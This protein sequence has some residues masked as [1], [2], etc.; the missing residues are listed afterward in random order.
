MRNDKPLLQQGNQEPLS[1]PGPSHDEETDPEEGPGRPLAD[2]ASFSRSLTE[3]SLE[4]QA[5]HP[6][7]S[8]SRPATYQR[9][10]LYKA[11]SLPE[12]WSS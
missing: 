2:A 10:D 6:P 4:C 8:V 12:S 3:G 1:H 5:A 11:V 7:G 9:G